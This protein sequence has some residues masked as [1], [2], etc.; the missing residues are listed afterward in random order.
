M[1][2]SWKTTDLGSLIAELLKSKLDLAEVGIERK[3][4][5]KQT[6]NMP[7]SFK[8]NL[9]KNEIMPKVSWRPKKVEVEIIPNVL[10]LDGAIFSVDRTVFGDGSNGPYLV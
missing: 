6:P 4:S 9:I 8:L 3:E 1:Q 5:W 2:E 10:R 7:P